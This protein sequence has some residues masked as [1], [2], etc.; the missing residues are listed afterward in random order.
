M[1]D[2]IT[3][4]KIVQKSI[5]KNLE[6]SILRISDERKRGE[7]MPTSNREHKEQMVDWYKELNPTHVLDIGVGEGTYKN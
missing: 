7:T 4:A 2:T 3:S 5:T 6:E 1:R